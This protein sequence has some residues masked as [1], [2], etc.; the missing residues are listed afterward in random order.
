MDLPNCFGGGC[1]EH[2]GRYGDILGGDHHRGV[3][4]G[5]SRADATSLVG[6][7]AAGPAGPRLDLPNLDCGG[8]EGVVDSGFEQGVDYPLDEGALRGGAL[9]PGIV[10]Y[11]AFDFGGRQVGVGCFG[12][13]RER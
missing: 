2:G 11:S 7:K 1:T 5:R 13:H 8:G 12:L 3:L 9:C 6:D 10:G 4:C